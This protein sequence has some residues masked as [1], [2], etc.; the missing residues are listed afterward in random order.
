MA[1]RNFLLSC[2]NMNILPDNL[3]NTGKKFNNTS[4]YSNLF[5]NKFNNY[6]TMLLTKLLKLEIDDV[7]LH[8]RNLLHKKE[9]LFY[10]I[11]TT[12]IPQNKL[13]NFFN[14]CDIKNKKIFKIQKSKLD[15]KLNNLINH[16]KKDLNLQKNSNKKP[17]FL[18]LTNTIIPNDVIDVVSLGRKHSLPS[19]IT[20]KDAVETVEE[21]I[22][23][24]S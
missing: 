2:K 14:L 4:F 9:K 1:R 6:K 22:L 16:S 7:I 21:K 24:T 20:K 18:N 12:K 3:K 17:W 10:K 13:Y 15:K 19:K 5:K 23:K 11:T 8:I